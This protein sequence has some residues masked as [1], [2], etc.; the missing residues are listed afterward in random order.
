MG[1]IEYA[2]YRTLQEV[3]KEM[4]NYR[5]YFGLAPRSRSAAD[6]APSGVSSCLK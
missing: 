5:S 6:S 1:L 2:R 3:M 4:L